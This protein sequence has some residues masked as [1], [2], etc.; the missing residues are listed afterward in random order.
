[1]RDIAH[2]TRPG[3]DVRLSKGN[4]SANTGQLGHRTV[5]SSARYVSAV[6]IG[7]RSPSCWAWAC[8]LV[9]DSQLPDITMT[10]MVAH[11]NY[12]SFGTLV[13]LNCSPEEPP[14]DK[15]KQMRSRD[16]E[17]LADYELQAARL[18]ERCPKSSSPFAYSLR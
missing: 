1:M 11:R 17:S 4:I 13:S 5:G 6:L 8:D 9:S 14:V 2:L 16:S 7:R 15:E 3:D 12:S 10:S 18:E